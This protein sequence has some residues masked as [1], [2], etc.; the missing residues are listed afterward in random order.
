MA[1]AV[2]AVGIR[3]GLPTMYPKPHDAEVIPTAV[4]TSLKRID[5]RESSTD[6]EALM[7][8]YF[9]SL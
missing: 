7:I 9:G 5:R 8:G 2:E 1:L 3:A 6:G 4:A